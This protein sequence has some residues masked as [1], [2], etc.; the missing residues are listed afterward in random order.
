MEADPGPARP[1]PHLQL[2]RW[3]RTGRKDRARGSEAALPVALPAARPSPRP[4][5]AL[6]RRCTIE[7]ADWRT[8]GLPEGTEGR[9]RRAAALGANGP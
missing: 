3:R 4:A 8:G 6:C 7:V 5:A 9:H 1:A 2:R